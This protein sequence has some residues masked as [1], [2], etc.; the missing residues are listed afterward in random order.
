MLWVEEL[1]NDLG[2]AI[3]DPVHDDSTEIPDATRKKDHSELN[4]GTTQTKP[5]HIQERES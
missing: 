3:G 1:R 2:L 4:K 5:E